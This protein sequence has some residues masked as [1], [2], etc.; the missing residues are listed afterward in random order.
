MVL[1]AASPI[2]WQRHFPRKLWHAMSSLTRHELEAI[3]LDILEVE[4]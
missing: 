3:Q 4:A 2:T 1:P